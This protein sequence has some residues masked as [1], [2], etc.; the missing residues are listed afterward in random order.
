MVVITR[1]T[2]PYIASRNGEKTY[3][4]IVFEGTKKQCECYILDVYNQKVN[5][6]YATSVAQAIRFTKKQRTID[7]LSRWFLQGPNRNRKFLQLDYDSRIW[8]TAT[9]KYYEQET[10]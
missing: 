3:W 5:A 2:C 10:A 9:K 8:R 6:P 1:T 7:G 4:T